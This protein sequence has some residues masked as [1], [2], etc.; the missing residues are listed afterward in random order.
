MKRIC[1]YTVKWFVVLLIDG[2]K[3]VTA[4][5]QNGV[6]ITQEIILFHKCFLKKDLSYTK[7]NVFLSCFEEYVFLWRKSF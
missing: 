4:A 3:W 7:L 2:E 1:E 5:S 6:C